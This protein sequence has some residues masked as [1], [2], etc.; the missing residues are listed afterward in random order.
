MIDLSNVFVSVLC[1][2]DYMVRWELSCWFRR[3]NIPADRIDLIPQ[4]G[5]NAAVDKNMWVK[6]AML[7]GYDLLLF[8]ECD[9]FPS[10]ET[11]P[12]LDMLY[13]ITCA[14]YPVESGERAW[15]HETAFHSGIWIVRK[16]TL[17]QL[18]PPWFVYS[19][20]AEQTIITGC[21]DVRLRERAMSKGYTIGHAGTA[22]H[23]PRQR[24]QG[25]TLRIRT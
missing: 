9:I 16:E 24:P 17:R 6:N 22:G 15:A 23:V 19:T 10:A 20:N 12:I 18:G 11:D 2:Q 8:A 13:D 1:G 21:T 3:H 14:S 4:T 5:R 25:K 7:K